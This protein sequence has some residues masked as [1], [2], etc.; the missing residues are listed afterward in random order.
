MAERLKTDIC[1][2]GAGSGGLSVAAA[3]AAFGVPVVLIERGKL[4][5][6]CLWTGWVPS[7]ERPSIVVIDLPA[8]AEI[9]VWQA[10]VGFPSRC[11]VHAPQAPMPQ[12]YFVPLRFK[13]SRSA[14]KRGIS[15]GAS[16]L[17]GLPLTVSE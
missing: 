3:A 4:G 15:A 16:T 8:A 11:T 12:P 17:A 7:A 14:H 5:G 9:R 10:R 2:I 6:D 1:V 13:M